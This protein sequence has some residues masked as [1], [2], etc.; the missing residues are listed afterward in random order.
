MSCRENADAHSM[1][2]MNERYFHVIASA[3]KQSIL[4]L[5]REM[6]CFAAL[7]MTIAFAIVR[8]RRQLSFACFRRIFISR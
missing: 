2:E 1:L 8:V 5:R 4:S 7:A 3:A 6:D